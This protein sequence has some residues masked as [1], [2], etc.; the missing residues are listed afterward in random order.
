MNQMWRK[1]LCVCVVASVVVLTASPQLA[2][3]QKKKPPA[4]PPPPTPTAQFEFVWIHDAQH[5]LWSETRGF[6]HA[7][8]VIGRCGIYDFDGV[9]RTRCFAW[10]RQAGVV[11][12]GEIPTVNEQGESVAEVRWFNPDPD[13]DRELWI[14]DVLDLNNQGQIVGGGYYCED[15]PEQPAVSI[16]FRW[17]PPAE[18]GETA[19]LEEIRVPQAWGGATQPCSIND[20]GDVAGMF[21]DGQTWRVFLFTEPGGYVD[22]GP[23]PELWT[24][25]RTQVLSERVTDSDGGQ[26]I[27]LVVS[28][29]R[30]LLDAG[31][32]ITRF[33]ARIG[34]VA[35]SLLVEDLGTLRS[36][37]SGYAGAGDINV[38]GEIVGAANSG[39]NQKTYATSAFRRSD[40]GGMVNLG[41]LSKDSTY[42]S[43]WA[44]GINDLGAI[45][46]MSHFEASSAIRPV[47]WTNQGM[48]DLTQVT[49][50][51]P[52]ASLNAKYFQVWRI[53][54]DGDIV[55]P[56]IGNYSFD[57]VP[58]KAFLLRRLLSP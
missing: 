34:D 39:S 51:I 21:H 36:A 1:W 12:L 26:W 31:S 44:H 16:A 22:L 20:A 37:N 8:L 11:Y 19:L 5:Q 30:P 48:A 13:A 45:V 23:R 54:N 24:S 53:N 55:G 7:G 38:W 43:S 2:L 49:S 33:T 52:W 40:A 57:T 10:T 29:Y 50:G 27:Q 42:K 56:Y 32:R 17:T 41:T 3:A 28:S 18:E 58:P 9:Q 46:G 15:W 25:P 35:N 47:L 6:N 14:N 4:D